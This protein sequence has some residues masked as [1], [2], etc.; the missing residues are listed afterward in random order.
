MR[1]AEV[2]IVERP[3]QSL[4]GRVWEGTFAEAA[5]GG[6]RR[7][8]EDMQARLAALPGLFKGP[9]VGLSWNERADGFRYFVGYE[10]DGEAAGRSDDGGVADARSGPDMDAATSGEARLEWLDLPTMRYAVAWHAEGDGA[11]VEHYRGMLHWMQL[12]GLSRDVTRMHHREE[13]P[14]DADFAGPPVMRLMC[15]WRPARRLRLSDALAR[16]EQSLARRSSGARRGRRP[17]CKSP[18]RAPYLFPLRE[19]SRDGA[20]GRICITARA[21]AAVQSWRGSARYPPPKSP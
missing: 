11:V 21:P 4:V 12:E 2:D 9:L 10:P 5:A 1:E 15:R 16:L 18:R 17:P 13:Y 20:T 3:A 7:T 14:L 19:K 6:V 8:L